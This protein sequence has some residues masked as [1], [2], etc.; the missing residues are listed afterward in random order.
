[1]RSLDTELLPM[2][3]ENRSRARE[4]IRK[5][6]ARGGTNIAEALP[7][8]LDLF[9]RD[10]VPDQVVFLTDGLPTVGSRDPKEILEKVDEA[11][12]TEARL[13]PWGVGYDV[14]A[15]LLDALAKENRGAAAYVT[16]GEDLEVRLS[17]FFAKMQDPVLQEPGLVLDGI[18]AEDVYPSPLPDLFAGEQILVVGRYEG[19][20]RAEVRLT[21]LVG[22]ERR[23][24]RYEVDFPRREGEN[25][26]V[27]RLWATR[28]V[29]HLLEEIRLHGEEEELKEEVIR[30]STRY[31]ILTPYTGYL[32]LE[33][34]PAW[35]GEPMPRRE[36][37]AHLE[38]RKAMQDAFGR[39]PAAAPVSGAG[40]VRT[41]EA[42]RYMKEADAEE[43]FG[44]EVSV[45]YVAG[46]TFE[47]RGDR[48]VDD[49]Y[50][51]DLPEVRVT[52]GTREYFEL[53]R[54]KRELRPFLALGEEVTVVLDGVAYI[55]EGGPE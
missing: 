17:A 5:M 23:T 34:E 15:R 18:D 12:D 6:Q 46:K 45:H 24:F 2:N 39:G 36:G 28:R 33:E 55:V 38:R 31:G 9:D 7:T 35:A 43:A 27:P 10:S 3:R 40:A 44:P 8:A 49:E 26:F 41:S 13:F 19:S 16:P 48:W 14:N 52:Y 47:K 22:D 25:D 51:E 29:G 50:A 37:H 20:G 42:L 21:G 4:F 1:V 32:V 30:L 53:L 11:N 54:E